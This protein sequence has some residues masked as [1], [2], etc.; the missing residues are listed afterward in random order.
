MS[1]LQNCGYGKIMDFSFS[2]RLKESL[3]PLAILESTVTVTP[4]TQF[5]TVPE[6]VDL[7][8]KVTNYLSSQQLL[9]HMIKP[10]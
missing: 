4:R 2:V 3:F 10:P 9:R 1:I 8:R 7:K 6:T 5:L